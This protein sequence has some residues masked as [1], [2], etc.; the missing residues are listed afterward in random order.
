MAHDHQHHHG[1]VTGRRLG[2]SVAL[3]LAFVLGEAAA[4]YR[5]RSLALMS[6]AGHNFA[7]A[8]ALIFSWSALHVARWPSHSRLTFGYHRA[9]IFAALVNALSLV[10]IAL[11][12]FWEA[13]ERLHTPRPVEGGPMIVVALVAIALNTLISLWLRG[14]AKHDLNIRSAYLHMLG[15][16]LSA[17]G[18]VAAGV[19]VTLTGNP[20]ADPIVSIVIGLL[21]LVSSWGILNESV[22]VLLEGVPK[23]IDMAD[24]ERAIAA[25][26]GVLGTHDLHVWTVGSGIVACSCHIV[27]T[28]QSISSG[29]QVLRAV[30]TVLRQ[31]FLVAH[32][33]IQV[34]VEGCDPDKLYCNMRP[35]KEPHAG[36]AH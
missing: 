33:T 6:D 35:T 22:N 15:D 9:G 27:V 7:D 8:L 13:F 3:T 32:S 20:V 30:A 23:G 29:Q 17:L 14:E 34:E 31:Q 36:H 28:E 1:S 26:P 25:V 4:G 2:L 21:I 10:V 19:V 24:L 16:A 11:F 5:A 12:I 18:V